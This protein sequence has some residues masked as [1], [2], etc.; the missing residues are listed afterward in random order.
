M[1]MST[2]PSITEEKH[3]EWFKQAFDALD[4]NPSEV[5][6][7][8]GVVNTKLYNILNGVAKPGYDTIQQILTAYPRLNANW[9]LKGQKPILH[10]SG[11]EIV[12][13]PLSGMARIPLIDA[14][15]NYTDTT[16][17]PTMNLLN[18]ERDLK[19]CV[20]IRLTDNSMSPRYTKGT[21]LLARP[22]PMQDWDYVN[23][24]LCVALYR[25]MFVMRRIKE[26]E[27][28][29]KNFLTLYADSPDAGFVIVKRDDLRSIWEV[30]E[31]VGGGVE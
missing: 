26:N 11:V 27:L 6:K 22:I 24:K 7:K 4:V 12:G 17:P 9:L 23:S 2:K 20:V 19:D 28:P 10:H 29:S 21:R 14:T 25:T 16:K 3:I 5:A 15:D 31:I 8:I 1:N 18:D 13:V 30:L